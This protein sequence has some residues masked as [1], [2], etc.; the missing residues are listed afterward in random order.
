MLGPA[1]CQLG[2][3][4]DPTEGAALATVILEHLREW[5]C[6]PSPPPIIPN[7]KNY[8]YAHPDVENAS[9]EFDLETLRP[10]YKLSIGVPGKSN[11]FAISLRLGLSKELVEAARALLSSDHV[12]AEDLIG[13][14]ETDRR[15]AEEDSAAKLR[16]CA[17]DTTN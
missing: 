8:A 16:C 4:T 1:G 13:E 9:V 11:A 6:E 2:A 5:V 12:R 7:F 3:G 10:T 17:A 14:I 15:R